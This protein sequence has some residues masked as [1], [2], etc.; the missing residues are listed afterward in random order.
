MKQGQCMCMKL[1]HSFREVSLLPTYSF[2]PN[3]WFLHKKYNDK[4]YIMQK[5][6][7]KVA[8]TAAAPVT[9]ERTC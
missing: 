5:D 6:L 2:L 8:T 9:T 4:K 1:K 7:P 3:H